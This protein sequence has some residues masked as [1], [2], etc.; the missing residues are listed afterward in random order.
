[1]FRRSCRCGVGNL[2]GA[3]SRHFFMTGERSG[4][5]KGRAEARPQDVKGFG[6]S[7][8]REASDGAVASTGGGGGGAGSFRPVRPRYGRSPNSVSFSERMP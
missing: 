5:K 6:V 4:P 3:W 2:A 1:M 7:F 8:Y